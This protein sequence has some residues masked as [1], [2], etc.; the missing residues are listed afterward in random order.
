MGDCNVCLDQDDGDGCE[1]WD[2]TIV[3]AR[4]PH[5]CC[6]CRDPI[7]R[8]VA[9]QRVALKYDGQFSAYRTCLACVEIHRALSCSGFRG[10][11]QLWDD[12]R[13]TVFPEMT[14]ACVEKCQGTAARL[15]LIERWNQ[16]KFGRPSADDAGRD[17][18][19]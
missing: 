3:R 16:W 17:S 14:L 10:L 11:E 1:F 7:L 8:G 18:A 5:R 15:K 19:Q 13:E 6:E 2:A 9:H 12:I 4:T